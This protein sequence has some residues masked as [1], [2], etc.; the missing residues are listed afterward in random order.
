M[1]KPPISWRRSAWIGLATA[2]AGRRWLFVCDLVG[3]IDRVYP[4]GD[5]PYDGDMSDTILNQPIIA[6]NAF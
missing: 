4:F 3:D 1:Q 2:A 5:A 6:A